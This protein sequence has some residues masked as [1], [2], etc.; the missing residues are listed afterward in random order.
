MLPR[1]FPCKSTAESAHICTKNSPVTKKKSVEVDPRKKVRSQ[2]ASL[3]RQNVW[4]V[5][6][7]VF[8]SHS[9]RFAL[10]FFF[11]RFCSFLLF[12]LQHF[13]P[14]ALFSL[15][16]SLFP[17]CCLRSRAGFYTHNSRPN[18]E[19]PS[20]DDNDVA[21]LKCKGS[22][23][24]ERADEKH[25]ETRGAV[26]LHCCVL[27]SFYN[28][29]SLFFRLNFFLFSSRLQLLE[30]TQNKSKKEQKCTT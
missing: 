27:F 15:S 20:N 23:R 29:F 21:N 30:I 25:G 11:A 22:S 6:S 4:C 10:L 8:Q 1:R 17:L 19:M 16:L 2:R 7:F 14:I 18:D 12:L 24:E 5:W 28:E 3:S 13:H 26:M 9:P